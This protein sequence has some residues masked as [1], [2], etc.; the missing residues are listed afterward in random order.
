MLITD[1]NE[2][3]KYSAPYR[4]WQG[5][6]GIEVTKGGR[7]F[8]TFY[9]GGTAEQ[10][11]NFAALIMSDDAGETF[12][13]PIAVAYD[14]GH[15][16]FDPCPWIDPL[17]RLWFFWA[18][19]PDHAVCAVVCDDPDADELVFSD[20]IK[21]PG[22]VMM[23]K[24]IVL[25]TGEWLFP[26]AVWKEGQRVYTLDIKYNSK[27]ADKRSLVYKSIDNGKT[28]EK[29][30]G[31]DVEGRI[32][33]EHMV[34][35]LK[36]GSLAMFVR[37]F[38]G[39]GVSYSYD[40]GKT[41]TKGGN[42]GIPG[43]CSRFHIG[44]LKSGRILMVNHHNFNG[45]NNL[46]ALISEDE[47]KSW[48]YT[49]LLDERG[50]SYPDVKEADDGYIYITYDHGRGCFL[51]SLDEVYADTREI[52]FAKITEEDIMAG[53][54]VSA[55]SF[56][57]KT[58]SK[59]GKYALEF[60]NPFNEISR[61]SDADLVNYLSSKNSDEIF[62][63]LFEHYKI[64]C[65][66]MHKLACK[67]LDSL[68]NEFEKDGA[69]KSNIIFEIVKLIRSASDVPGKDMP[70]IERIKDEIAATL[71]EDITVRKIAENIGI[72]NY[73]M[74]HLFKKEMGITVSDYRNSVKMSHAKD[75][76][77]HTD[78][79]ISDIAYECGFGSGSYFAKLFTESENVSPSKYR[80][81]LKNNDKH[82]KDVIYSNMLDRID[83]LGDIDIGLL[84]KDKNVKTYA[85]TLPPTDGY[86][87]LHESAIIEYNGKLI[88]A[89]YNNVKPVEL[90]GET[91][92][93]FAVSED[94]GKTW[95]APITIANDESGKILFCPPVFGI[96]NGKLYLL[97]NQMVYPDHIHSLDLY[98]YNEEKNEFNM[99]WSRP[100]PFKLN[101][102]V[103]KLSNGKLILPGRVG[104]LDRFPNTPAAL[105]SDSGR[106]DA[107]WRLVKM[108]EN[109]NLA[110]GSK[111][112]YPEVS[113]IIDGAKIYAFTRNDERNVPLAYVSEDNG[114][115]FTGPYTHDI[116]LSSSK[117]YSGTLSDGR[118]YIIGNL[119]FPRAKLVILFSEPGE[120]KFTKGIVL[121]DGHSDELGYGTRWHYPCAYES[122]GKLY[123]IYTV[124]VDH[125][126]RRGAVLSIIELDKI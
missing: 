81:L 14:D 24:P 103:Y 106:I 18:Y 74:A 9:S 56:L 46:T 111:L 1:K 78:M 110:D 84:E 86:E 42:S 55:G 77:I 27:T 64:N 33:D 13:E 39:I 113:L 70:I 12:S 54:I 125:Q 38:Y 114:E 108:Q 102:N 82:D 7:I 65:C 11:G 50:C 17:G 8:S 30:G 48:K 99:L 96:D 79:K 122:N 85:V 101:T 19:C 36:D 76:L 67:T 93:R 115:S 34:L 58:I 69:D 89:W 121:Q 68:I 61:F 66:N 20:V 116:P 60:E 25:T 32:F 91:P 52:L 120:V 22:D 5:I 87:F 124:S 71:K 62:S 63:I 35:E 47:C 49:L 3:K 100:I 126:N 29:L 83:I 51:H 72:S 107:E 57:K 90:I 88:A 94:D 10:I 4:L 80:N 31:S 41:W 95:S 23:N 97:M 123:V 105:I 43:P 118:N 98:E 16:C 37:T 92:I 73:Y 104:E 40:R 45:R 44:R 112:I 15:R 53:K 28:F 2:L 6:P 59:L 75:L 117:I 26:I 109:G 119:D 21:L